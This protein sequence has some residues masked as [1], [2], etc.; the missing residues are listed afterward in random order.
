MMNKREVGKKY[1]TKAKTYLES[2]GYKIIECNF[3][4]KIGEIDI[5]GENEG[6]VCFIEVKYREL[7]S[8]AKGM[9]AVDK[10]KQK[11]IFNVA[12]VYLMTRKLSQNTPCRFDV[13]SIDGDEITLIKNAFVGGKYG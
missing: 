10:N 11:K 13:V 2:N 5:I 6:Y 12:S 1:E 8:L 4:C 9:Y 3:S 7:N